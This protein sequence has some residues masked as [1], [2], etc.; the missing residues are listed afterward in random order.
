MKTML[1][2]A[3][4]AAGACASSAAAG[5]IRNRRRSRAREPIGERQVLDDDRFAADVGAG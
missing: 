2:A 3:L 1:A 4:L 5:E